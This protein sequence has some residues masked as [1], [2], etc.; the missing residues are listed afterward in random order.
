MLAIPSPPPLLALSKFSYLRDFW[1]AAFANI[2][3]IIF[4]SMI[5]IWNFGVIRDLT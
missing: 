2:S 1:L 3:K 5:S 4:L